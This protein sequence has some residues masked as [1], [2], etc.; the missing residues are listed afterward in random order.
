M[1]VLIIGSTQYR[2]RIDE[3]AS[4]LK[5]QAHDVALPAFDDHPGFDELDICKYNRGLVEQAD[6]V[7]IIWDQRS[8]FTIF[9][10]GMAF[11][12]R[13]KIK[14]VYLESKQF[15]GVMRKWEEEMTDGNVS[16]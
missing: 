16:R 8:L 13:K 2:E 5:S 15:A 14:V 4:T 1:K 11:A 12:L 9:D 7:H 6:E 3:Y 10:L